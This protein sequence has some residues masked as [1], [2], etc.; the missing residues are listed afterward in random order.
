MWKIQA[1]VDRMRRLE[2]EVMDE[3]IVAKMNEQKV[4]LMSVINYGRTEGGVAFISKDD[5][6][7]FI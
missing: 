2:H 7:A 1:I 6:K 5:G 4:R 3:R